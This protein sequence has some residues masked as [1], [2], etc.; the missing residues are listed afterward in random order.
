MRCWMSAAGQSSLSMVSSTRT[1]HHC[2]Y[3]MT[4]NTPSQ[5]ENPADLLLV[6]GRIATQDDRPASSSSTAAR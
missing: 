4:D 3:P 1:G 2:F 5:A 6:N